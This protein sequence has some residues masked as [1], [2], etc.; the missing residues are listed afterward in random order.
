[1]RQFRSLFLQ[2]VFWI[3]V[4][5]LQRVLFLIFYR[6]AIALEQIPF[7]EILHTFSSALKLDI[8][9]SCYLLV[10]PF[11]LQIYRSFSKAKWP[12]LAN[13]IYVFIVLLL[14]LLIS[15]GEIGIY[16]EWKSK[17]SF[18]ALSYLHRVDEV[19]NSI[20]SAI[21]FTLV[22]FVV[23]QLIIYYFVY[24]RLIG[25]YD[26]SDLQSGRQFYKW[27]FIVIASVM[28]FVGM[29][30][31]LGAIPI[32][33]GDS[34]FSEHDILNQCAVNN[35]YHIVFSIIDYYQF[36]EKGLLFQFMPDEEARK[37]VKDLH[38][39]DKDT[40]INILKTKNP[41]IVVFLLESWSAD[42]IETI[43]G[44]TG[45]TPEFHQLEKE[46]ILFTNFYASGNRSQQAIAS[47]FSGLPGLPITTLT[48]HPQKY[49]AYPSMIHILN[50][51]GYFTS[52][53]FAGDMNYGNIKS[54]L[55]YNQFDRL[56]DEDVFDRD[57]PRGKLGYHDE[58][59][60]AKLLKDIPGMPEPFFLG[61]LTVS[62]HSPY[63]FP[64]DRPIQW[65]KTEKD[66][67]NS[68][69][70]T[71]EQL[72]KF[73]REAKTTDWYQNTLFVILA[74]HSHT[75]HKHFY[76]DS[77]GY[78]KIPLLLIGGALV[79][80][81]K[82]TVSNRLCGNT[83]VPATILGQLDLPEKEFF[84]SKNIFNPYSPQF[85]YFELNNGFGWKTTLGEVIA[86]SNVKK[87]KFHN[88][89]NEKKS[90]FLKEGEAYIQVLMTDLFS[91]KN[92]K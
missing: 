43:S 68:A 55:I 90:E 47:V 4:F 21:F 60:F 9:T 62:S 8:T 16:G 37:I 27:L 88:I 65:I 11:F 72:G 12:V 25:R 52:F 14:Y 57:Q 28:L 87:Y 76:V 69:H 66:Y 84:W 42:L 36:E 6:H 5:D 75:S 80:S 26:R 54:Y 70:Y 39:I 48:D 92:R 22:A 77:F 73:F 49:G 32:A 63:D 20:S 89:P 23:I 10:I 45:I 74:D 24:K 81:L 83:D 61:T 71:D 41:N 64:G 30:G 56:V 33:F 17:L 79:D 19:Y 82:G 18:R 35:G 34:Y 7:M 86:N 46:G 58:A 51:A 38:H 53:Y 40:T 44:D 15:A 31:S 85:A 50:G 1:M 29:R 91:N 59:L 3:V 2:F 13:N 78:R 67:L